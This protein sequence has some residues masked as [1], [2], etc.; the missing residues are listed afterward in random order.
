MYDGG[1]K[2]FL[3]EA[4]TWWRRKRLQ[5]FSFW[6]GRPH[7]FR[8]GMSV[9]FFVQVT[10]GYC[11]M[12]IAMTYQAELFFAVVGGLGVGH[13]IFNVSVP[14]GLENTPC[15]HNTP[16]VQRDQAKR[17]RAAR[18]K[19]GEADAAEQC[20][21]L[22]ELQLIEPLAL[23]DSSRPSALAGVLPGP[24]GPSDVLQSLGPSDGGPV[25]VIW[26]SVE[27]ITCSHCV[28]TVTDTLLS[29][30][31]VVRVVVTLDGR[32]E[33]AY[34]AHG[35]G[36]PARSEFVSSAI[37]AVEATGRHASYATA[38]AFA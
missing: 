16:R 27:P 4:L 7:L 28:N 38:G 33:I 36:G 8:L 23:E 17:D 25:E 18:A 31:N 12:L 15:C 21:E 9:A 22:P 35:A 1:H 34:T 13:L 37:A 3:G 30:P 19:A 26:L 5:K 24:R 32:A 11:N 10:L 14:V 2:F 20:P 6:Q 29:L